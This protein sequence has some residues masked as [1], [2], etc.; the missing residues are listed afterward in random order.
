MHL[1]TSRIAARPLLVVVLMVSALVGVVAVA[2]VAPYL[3]GNTEGAAAQT[4]K[5]APPGQLSPP[6]HLS[7]PGQLSPPGHKPGR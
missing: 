3:S 1:F 6:G 5:V 4:S 7:A 2:M